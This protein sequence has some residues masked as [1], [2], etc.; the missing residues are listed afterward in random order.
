MNKFRDNTMIRE[1]TKRYIK[2]CKCYKC[3]IRSGN[4]STNDALRNHGKD[5]SHDKP[6]K[7]LIKRVK[8]VK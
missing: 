5:T 2:T 8:Y 4:G 1:R 3:H 7:C 6:N